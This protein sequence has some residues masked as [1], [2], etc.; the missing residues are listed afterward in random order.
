M[1]LFE[2]G[3]VERRV[4]EKV[5]SIDYS[6]TPWES[7]KPDIYQRQIRFK[8]DEKLSRYDGSVT[9]TQQKSALPDNKGWVIEEVMTL[10]GIPLGDYF[11]V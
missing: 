7:V 3:P 4:M 9:S 6:V 5:G 1:E 8:F 2:G 10:Q 11:D